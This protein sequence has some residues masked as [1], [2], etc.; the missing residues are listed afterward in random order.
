[1]QR[2][3]PLLALA[4]AY[5]IQVWALT[6]AAWADDR[7]IDRTSLTILTLNA[8]WLWD[9][10]TP[11]EG[12]VNFPWKGNPALARAHMAAVA[13]VIQ[14]SNPDIIC[15][16][17]VENLDALLTFASF[18]PPDRGYRPYFVKGIDTETGQDVALLTRVDPEAGI[19]QREEGRAPAGTSTQSVSKN[20]YALFTAGDL[21]FALT[22]VH[23]LAFPDDRGRVAEREAQA[24]VIRRLEVGLRHLG[25][26][27]V[28]VGDLNDYD[29]NQDA[30]DV[31]HNVPITHVLEWLRGMDPSTPLDDL[32][33]VAAWIWPTERYT[34]WDDQNGNGLVEPRELSAIDHILVSPEL[35]A[36]AVGASIPHTYNPAL[37]TDHF[38]VI[39][40]LGTGNGPPPPLFPAVRILALLPN[41]VGSELDDEE[42]TIW[43]TGLVAVDLRSWK[44]RD[45]ANTTWLLDSLGTLQPGEQKTIRR[46]HQ[47]MGLNNSGDTIR[48]E[49][50]A[51][52]E[53][54]RVTYGAAATGQRVLTP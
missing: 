30:L 5:L 40:R 13:A 20:F 42:A 37:V 9:G 46:N 52:A 24:V 50:A 19:V 1:M 36:R 45:V 27:V 4:F 2:T 29:G 8:E 16:Q 10:V 43:N 48:L 12:Q 53:R 28:V 39:V 33:N 26:P 23:L 31:R 15:L 38:P 34:D 47:Q 49:D 51:G 54:H 22:D 11:E 18:F 17:E 7:R 32:K 3:R 25:Y 41:P 21:R 6:P 14:R 44:L 35:A